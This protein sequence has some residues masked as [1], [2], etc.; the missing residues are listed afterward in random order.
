MSPEFDGQVSL[1]IIRRS[2]PVDQ[3]GDLDPQNIVA[4][5]L[6]DRLQGE[7]HLH[8]NEWVASARHVVMG[9]T[10]GYGAITGGPR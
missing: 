8:V 3:A 5:N 4:E 10:A 6:T 1:A 7:V 2:R 9:K